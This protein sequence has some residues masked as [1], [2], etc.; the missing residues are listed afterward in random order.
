MS[1]PQDIQG[2]YRIFYQG[3]ALAGK[4]TNYPLTVE[5]PN[6]PEYED[7]IVEN[8]H[9]HGHVIRQRTSYEMGLTHPHN[10]FPGCPVLL[11]DSVMPV[12]F[13][14]AGQPNHF[15]IHPGIDTPGHEDLAMATA[16]AVDDAPKV[17]WQPN[18]HASVWRFEKIE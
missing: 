7:W 1:D 18:D 12:R 10:V 8:L 13:E 16:P 3:G 15:I 4:R 11:N 6:N 5:A 9:E 14:P 17:S 2:I